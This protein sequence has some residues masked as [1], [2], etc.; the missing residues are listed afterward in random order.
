MVKKL[1]E[2]LLSVVRGGGAYLGVGG[3]EGYAAAWCALEKALHDEE[4][5]VNFL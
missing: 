4:G 2:L 3:W 1:Q 5:L